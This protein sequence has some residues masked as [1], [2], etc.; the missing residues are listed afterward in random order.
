MENPHIADIL[1][2][3]SDF[4]FVGMMKNMDDELWGHSFNKPK[5]TPERI[6]VLKRNIEDIIKIL[7]SK[8]KASLFDVDMRLTGMYPKEM[9]KYPYV[10]LGGGSIGAGKMLEYLTKMKI[11]ERT[12][13]RYSLK[14][15][16]KNLFVSKI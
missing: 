4:D 3:L 6:T 11:L 14:D 13:E 1:N 5:I 15:K 2:L 16:Y 7:Y 9:N 12:K 8:G 10:E